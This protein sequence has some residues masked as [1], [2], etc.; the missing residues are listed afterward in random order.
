MS[1]AK[2][3]HTK[4]H[5]SDQITQNVLRAVVSWTL[6][7]WSKCSDEEVTHVWQWTAN[8]LRARVTHCGNNT[9]PC[10]SK[11]IVGLSMRCTQ[12]RSTITNNWDDSIWSTFLSLRWS[13]DSDLLR[14]T[15]V[16]PTGKTVFYTFNWYRIG[17]ITF[18][19]LF[20]TP[21]PFPTV[22]YWHAD[23]VGW[24]GGMAG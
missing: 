22:A 10:S 24:R 17:L 14:A 15:S 9:S 4:T 13:A 16:I 23:S 1:S 12:T 21:P 5:K 6:G 8:C 18:R 19:S 20:H 3:T 11:A 7:C 2:N